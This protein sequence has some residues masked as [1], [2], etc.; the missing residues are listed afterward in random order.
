MPAND[1]LWTAPSTGSQLQATNELMEVYFRHISPEDQRELGE[2]GRKAMVQSHLELAVEAAGEPKIGIVRQPR[3]AVVQVVHPDIRFLVDS[4]SAELNKMDVP[5][6]VI[7]H[8]IVVAHHAQKDQRLTAIFE[9]PAHQPRLSGDA[10]MPLEHIPAAPEGQHAELQSWISIQTGVPLEADQAANLEAAVEAALADVRSANEDFELLKEAA[11]QTAEALRAEAPPTARGVEPAAELLEWMHAD[12]FVFL[13]YREYDLATN[14]DGKQYLDANRETGLGVLREQTSTARPLTELGQQQIDNPNPLI[15][16]K[17]NSRSRVYRNAYM[18]FIAAKKY[19]DQGT[20]VGERR[21]L[22]LWRPTLEALPIDQVPYARELAIQVREEAGFAFDSHSAAALDH[23]LDRYPLD[24]MLQME[25]REI[26][27]TMLGILGLGQ[28]RKTRLFLRPDIYGRFMTAMV[29]LPRDRYNTS[30][31]LRIQD[32]L[33]RHLNAESLDYSVHLDESVLARVFY[34]IQL[35]QD[36]QG[37]DTV[38]QNVIEDEL[39]MAVRSWKEGVDI[40]AV[41]VFGENS[42]VEAAQ[43]WDEAF[44]PN[45]RVRFGIDDA[46]EDISRFTALDGD[47]PAIYLVP[48]ETGVRMKIYS[49]TSITLTTLMPILGELGVEVTDEYPFH[50]TPR[51]RDTYHLY[52]VGLL[53]GDDVNISSVGKLLEDTVAAAIVGDIAADSFNK[54]VLHQGLAPNLVA[55]LRAYGHYL[56]QLQL[57]NSLQFMAEILL[58]NPAVTAGLVEYFET[59]FDPNIDGVGTEPEGQAS[60]ERLEKL[61][62]IVD[63]LHERIDQVATLDADRLLRH[64]LTVMQATDRTN[65]YTGHGWHS[66][67]LAPQRIPFAPHPQPLHE[68]WVH[69]PEISGVHFRFGAIARGGLRW[70][71]RREDFRTEVLSLVQ[72]QQTKNAVIVPQG[73]KGGFYAHQLPDPA[74]DRNAWM[75]AGREAYRTFMRGMLDITDNQ[76][77][78]DG[79]RIIHTHDNI[80]RYDDADTYLVVAADKG[81]AGFSDTANEIAAEY[82]HWLGDAYASGG[83]VGYDHKEMGITAR[84]AFESVKSHF[85]TMGVDVE[86]EPFTVV[87]IGDMSGDVFGNGMRRS[88]HTKLVAAFNHLHIFIDPNPDPDVAFDERERLYFKPRS[89]WRDYDPDLISPGGGVFDRSARSVEITEQMQ[90]V[91]GIADGITEMTPNELLKT[92]L[93]APV[94][95]I[96]NGG[97][98]TYIKASDESHDDVG[99]RAN[100]PIRINGEQIQAKVVGEGGNLGATQ[101]GRVEAARNGVLIN[102]DAIDNSGGVDAS[103]HEVNIKILIDTMLAEGVINQDERSDLLLS[104][105]DEVAELVLATNV[106]QNALL[107]LEEGLEDDWTPTLIRH[108]AWLEEH[109]GLNREQEAIPSEEE[110]RKRLNDGEGFVTPELAILAS[111][112]KIQLMQDLLDSPLVE[113]EWFNDWLYAYFPQTLQQRAGDTVLRHPLAHEIIAMLVAN[114]V[115]DTGGITTVFRAQE[116][117]GADVRTVVESFLA[118]QEIYLINEY[119]RELEALPNSLDADVRW[120]AGYGLRRLTDRLTRWIIHHQRADLLMEQRIEAYQDQVQALLPTLTDMFIGETKQRFEDDRDRLITAGFSQDLAAR[121]ARIFEAYSLLDIVELSESIDVDARRVAGIFFAL[122]EEFGVSNLLE[123]ITGLSR[124][125]RWDSLSRV[126]MREDLYTWLT[127]LTGSV[128]LTEGNEEMNAQEALKHWEAD[129]A[130]RVARVRTFLDGVSEQLHEQA[131]SQ[132]DTDL[133]MLTVVLRRLRTLIL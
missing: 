86:T 34:R 28:R 131:A 23:E 105:T 56:R 35:P 110:L 57:P 99:D 63:S 124:H 76:K 43:V 68:I 53:A 31:R 98:G 27:D 36:W 54:L 111:Y 40:Q 61:D 77:T 67:K 118:A 60:A 127:E 96:Y 95:L 114:H 123:L 22:G 80:I 94:D 6:S 100:D 69:S 104:M 13:G 50:I 70:S 10:V 84:G 21:F 1:P 113:D 89:T 65:V 20:V 91:F 121:S 15:I 122:H 81:T 24:E 73:A 26:L 108:T 52:D 85:G 17:T 64:Y 125:T 47:R 126:S 39:V 97:I 3:Y 33:V 12:N 59:R 101:A 11:T 116:E 117:T 9:L 42:G 18:D 115:I 49:A 48:R 58:A 78:V 120:E 106:A 72:T 102:M 129:H 75:E 19:D 8:P 107:R 132:G 88:R 93:Q 119:R 29:F 83:S 5:M 112:T 130:R 16:T 74:V 32:V 103:D 14:G 66:F 90:Q 30:V 7:V 44:P 51:N 46:M 2:G 128:V 4:V 92:V 41:T 82:D 109:A 71:D 133:S 25:P 62:A 87:G 55:V 45:Y 37:Y 79:Q 38:D